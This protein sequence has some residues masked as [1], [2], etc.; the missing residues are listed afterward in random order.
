[1]TK[2][3]YVQATNPHVES[4]SPVTVEYLHHVERVLNGHALQLTRAFAICH[5]Q[6]DMYRLKSAMINTS[7]YPPPL[8]SV[9]KDHKVVPEAQKVFGPP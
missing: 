9:R 8:R 4:D 7:I 6:G 2:E 5:N 3:N 1:M